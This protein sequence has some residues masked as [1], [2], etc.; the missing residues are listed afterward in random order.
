MPSFL[1]IKN[2]P[3]YTKETAEAKANLL[4]KPYIR[5]G[6]NQSATAKELG[7]TSEAI[8]QRLKRKPVQDALQRYLNS[9]KLKE[10]LIKV[11]NEGLS[12]NKVISCNVIAND[13]EGMK[14]ANSMTKDFI[15][16]PDHQSRHKFWHDLLTAAGVL[17]ETGKG[18]NA[19]IIV[20]IGD[21]PGLLSPSEAS[22]VSYQRG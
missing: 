3:R 16:V 14:D 12:A 5:N 4:I 17:K 1:F 22:V 18:F 2:M 21:K 8:N 10:K 9:P 11:A 7:V 20:R 19:T 15:D 13:G 6:L